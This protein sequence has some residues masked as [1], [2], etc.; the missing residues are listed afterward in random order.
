[1]KRIQ[2]VLDGLQPVALGKSG[3]PCVPRAIERE[4]IKARQQWSRQRAKVRKD[5]PA[6]FLHQIGLLLDAVLQAR[7]VAGHVQHLALGIEQPAVIAAAQPLR[8]GGT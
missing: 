2:P 8:V 4:K 1:M 3:D 6:Q 7:E 5:Q